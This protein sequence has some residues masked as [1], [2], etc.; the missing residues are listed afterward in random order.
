MRQTPAA[1]KRQVKLLKEIKERNG[2]AE[3]TYLNLDH[4]FDSDLVAVTPQRMSIMES[5]LSRAITKMKPRR[6]TATASDHLSTPSRAVT[7]TSTLIIIIVGIIMLVTPLWLLT[8]TSNLWIRL[9][10]ITAFTFVVPPL[11]FVAM[12][13]TP[14]EM[15]SSVVA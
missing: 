2:L 5:L 13:A 9:G 3:D 1:T 10:Q 14:W 8:T 15:L 7:V 12:R 11:L 6:K 4:G